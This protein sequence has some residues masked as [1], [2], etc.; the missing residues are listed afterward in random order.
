M[1]TCWFCILPLGTPNLLSFLYH[2]QPSGVSNIL[3]G[4]S[5]SLSV[6][7]IT[8]K[9]VASG[10]NKAHRLLDL[11]PSPMGHYTSGTFVLLTLDDANVRKSTFVSSGEDVENI[12]SK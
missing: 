3:L 10:G 12:S 1:C 5:A 8:E 6:D 4:Y 7:F 2:R 11:E 9:S